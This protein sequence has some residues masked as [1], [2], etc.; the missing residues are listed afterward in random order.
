MVY[1][2]YHYEKNENCEIEEC[3]ALTAYV[4]V[5]TK[6]IKIGY[7]GSECNLFSKIDFE[8]DEKDRKLKQ[9]VRYLKK[10]VSNAKNMSL[11]EVKKSIMRFN[12]LKD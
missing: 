5:D 2:N 12:E 7:Y 10:L 4:R 11:D 8:Q 6:W 9:R 1:R 3:T